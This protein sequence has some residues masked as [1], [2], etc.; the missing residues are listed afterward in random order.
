MGTSQR[1][2]SK[3][4]RM[5]SEHSVKLDESRSSS[6][7]SKNC[8]IGTSVKKGETD[9]KKPKKSSISDN[10]Q[11]ASFLPNTFQWSTSKNFRISSESS[12]KLDESHS[13]S[14]NSRNFDIGTSFRRGEMD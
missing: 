2:A 4:S 10:S 8:D 11:S 5:I 6:W 7:N 3:N 13:P 12:V 1:S 14:Q 9:S